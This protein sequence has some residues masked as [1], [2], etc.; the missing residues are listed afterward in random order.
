MNQK[1]LDMLMKN[2]KSYPQKTLMDLG[3]TSS[4]KKKAE[5]TLKSNKR[6]S[7][8]QPMKFKAQKD[9]EDG[10]VIYP[11]EVY[12]S[13]PLVRY[14]ALSSLIPSI[15]GITF[16]SL[17]SLIFTSIFLDQR[18]DII[19]KAHKNQLSFGFD[20]VSEKISIQ[21]MEAIN[22]DLEGIIRMRDSLLDRKTLI[23]NSDDGT[24]LPQF[25]KKVD[26]KN[27]KLT[28][29]S[30]LELSTNEKIEKF[31]NCLLMND[32]YSVL[33]EA[34]KIRNSKSS[35]AST[36]ITQT[37]ADQIPDYPCLI[38]GRESGMGENYLYDLTKDDNF[39]KLSDYHKELKYDVAVAITLSPF[40]IDNQS[41]F[42][43][44][45]YLAFYDSSAFYINTNKID[46]KKTIDTTGYVRQS[47]DCSV[48]GIGYSGKTSGYDPRCRP[49]MI[50]LKEQYTV[51]SSKNYAR[52]GDFELDVPFVVTQPY[53][54]ATSQQ[55]D[56]ITIC[57]SLTRKNNSFS[58]PFINLAICN[59]M[60]FI[61]IREFISRAYYHKLKTY[62]VINQ[63]LVDFKQA[64]SD[65]IDQHLND[66]DIKK[67]KLYGQEIIAHLLSKQLLIG[68]SILYK[69]D[70]S[71]EH[72]GFVPFY[73]SWEDSEIKKKKDCDIIQRKY[74]TTFSGLSP[75]QKADLKK[76][77]DLCI[78]QYNRF[79][80]ITDKLDLSI[81]EWDGEI[82]EKCKAQN[83]QSKDTKYTQCSNFLK[84]E[85][86]KLYI[87][88]NNTSDEFSIVFSNGIFQYR[89]NNNIDKDIKVFKIAF[90]YPSGAIHKRF[91][92]KFD[93]K[94][95]FGWLV[96]LQIAAIVIVGTLLTRVFYLSS[97]RISISLNKLIH[98]FKITGSK[99]TVGI[100]AEEFMEEPK[101]VKDLCLSFFLVKNIFEEASLAFDSGNQTDALI[102][103]S[104][105][106]NFYERVNNYVIAGI[107][108]NNIGNIHYNFKRYNQAIEKYER[109]IKY[110]SMKNLPYTVTLSRKMNLVTAIL[111]KLDEMKLEEDP[112]HEKQMIFSKNV[113]WKTDVRRLI[114]KL[115]N[116][117]TALFTYFG[118]T[119]DYRRC[120]FYGGK[121]SWMHLEMNNMQRCFIFLDKVEETYETFLR[122]FKDWKHRQ[123][124][125]EFLKDQLT[126]EIEYLKSQIYKRK[127]LY[128]KVGETLTKILKTGE[129]YTFQM[130]RQT[131]KQLSYLFKSQKIPQTR[132]FRNLLEQSLGRYS[133]PKNFIFILDYSKSMLYGGKIENAI[134]IILQ[135]WD[136]YVRPEDKVAFLRF[137][138]NVETVFGLQEKSINEFQKRNRI[139]SSSSPRDRTSLYDAVIKGIKVIE[140]SPKDSES[141]FI[142][143]C[144]GKDTA[145][146][147]SY[148]TVIE[149][150]KRSADK[151]FKIITV[152]LAVDR[153]AKEFLVEIAKL[154]KGGIFIDATD[155]KFFMSFDRICSYIMVNEGDGLIQESL[156]GS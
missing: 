87:Y 132:N 5:E 131:L 140:R 3:L 38:V 119:K 97:K 86:T 83:Y 59:D 71:T 72:L 98:V 6:F 144:D 60:D 9:D 77:L 109:S 88:N 42:K 111:G 1:T 112:Y 58:A 49:W 43:I 79:K 76:E 75:G 20:S 8:L 149:T 145:S 35:T 11:K 32:A 147:N 105:G 30:L 22:N 25:K 128:K 55:I 154:S 12:F 56:E 68:Y 10:K 91:T 48:Q 138:L 15:F 137:N 120:I 80:Q 152:G 116:H 26:S 61:A 39:N 136:T 50:N 69:K 14:L 19:S 29:Y 40:F 114:Q 41:K 64:G 134:K 47:V 70:H 123:E 142:V 7:F 21:L 94:T 17:F 90:I 36:N 78:N 108:S 31:Q 150:I 16:V 92:D 81:K 93:Y 45:R 117:C 23:M 18:T 141:F 27:L 113:P 51:Y 133:K 84:F 127:K 4:D 37:L 13:G 85:S 2:I 115:E 24:Y 104:V 130:R 122:S 96:A 103:Y 101:E 110:A 73:K 95:E 67:D 126:I 100:K 135:I 63:G 118:E 129:R 74:D 156:S 153:E 65:K 107:I 124:E 28:C 57:T 66:N 139:E 146:V 54:S 46:I 62:E 99:N 151:N 82:D 34:E 44:Q 121:L 148:R 53:V 106:L 143:F 155:R 89:S 102:K 125:Y 33:K 52:Y